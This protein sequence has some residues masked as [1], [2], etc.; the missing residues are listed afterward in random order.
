MK[1]VSIVLCPR[2]NNNSFFRVFNQIII[3]TRYDLSQVEV[4]VVDNNT[5][6]ALKSEVAQF[7]AENSEVCSL[8]YI[9]N[10]NEGGIAMACNRAIEAADSQW[11]V[12]MDTTDTYIY[13]PR[14][15]QYMVGNMSEED[16][17]AGFRIAG[18]LTAGENYPEKE[19]D[20]FIQ[21][22]VFIAF[23]E[24]MKLN[25]FL[26]DAPPDAYDAVHSAQC[27][28]LGYQLKDLPR[29]CSYLGGATQDWHDENREVK[30]YLIAN[31][32][33]LSHYK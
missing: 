16:Y 22:A 29:I 23:T 10:N 1:E 21:G 13:D 17:T 3:R 26:T 20:V 4:I 14:W 27:L 8:R 5:D 33:G 19:S 9:E 30:R 6:P 15:L 18:T 32:Q 24:Y 25:P 12:Y 2:E 31:V 28:A 11:F 7:V